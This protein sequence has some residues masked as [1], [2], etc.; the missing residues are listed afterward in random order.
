[1]DK[2]EKAL[3]KLNRKE[4]ERINGL[5]LKLYSGDIKNLDIKKL[6]GREDIFRIRRGDF[7]IIY[8]IQDDIVYILGIERRNERT[9]KL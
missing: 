8:R 1:M 2:I 7:R 9:Y 3:A 4:R 5:L 6:Q